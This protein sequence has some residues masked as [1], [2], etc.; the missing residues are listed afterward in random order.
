MCRFESDLGHHI[1]IH[2]KAVAT[3]QLDAGLKFRSV[4]F[5]S[6][7]V[8]QYGIIEHGELAERSKAPVC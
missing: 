3:A 8:F 5:N 2:S 6:Q 7:S 1:E 4:G